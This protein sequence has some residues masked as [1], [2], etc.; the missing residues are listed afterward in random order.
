MRN[1]NPI[2]IGISI[3]IAMGVGEWE[4]S[5]IETHEALHNKRIY[6]AD[7]RKTKII[8][9]QQLQQRDG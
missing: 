1:R 4:S 7:L 8:Q 2:R 6:F 5:R 9:L 3:S